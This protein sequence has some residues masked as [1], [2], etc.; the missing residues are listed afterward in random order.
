LVLVTEIGRA[1][2]PQTAF[3]FN[4]ENKAKKWI[5]T[6]GKNNGEDLAT[7]Q[8]WILYLLTTPYVTP[9]LWLSTL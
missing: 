6:A 5:E 8:C 7:D 1:P 9:L 4:F 3:F 2:S